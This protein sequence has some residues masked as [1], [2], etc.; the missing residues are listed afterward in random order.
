MSSRV[1]IVA[2]HD[3]AKLNPSTAKCVTCAKQMNAGSI[4]VA[5]LSDQPDAVA[6]EAAKRD[7]TGWSSRSSPTAKRSRR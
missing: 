1:L 7:P 3:G 5:V 6:A 2:E 4:D